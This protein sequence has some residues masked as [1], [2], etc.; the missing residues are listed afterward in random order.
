MPVLP[1]R[2]FAVAVILVGLVGCRR[3]TPEPPASSD[4]AAATPSVARVADPAAR[5]GAAL[6]FDAGPPITGRDDPR[7]DMLPL[8]SKL[9]IEKEHRPSTVRAETIA[10]A[11]GSKLGLTYTDRKQV[12]GFPVLASYCEKAETDPSIDV[13]VCEYKDAST[14]QKGRDI[15]RKMFKLPRREFVV[16]QTTWISVTRISDT[17]AAADKAKKIAAVLKGLGTG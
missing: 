8:F 3:P 16:A 5:A 1:S 12:A 11:L 6:T 13:V 4:P 10:G 2:P 9:Q 15:A 17:P 14:L 7:F